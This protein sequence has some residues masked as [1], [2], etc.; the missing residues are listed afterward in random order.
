MVQAAVA[1]EALR[2]EIRTVERKEKDLEVVVRIANSADR[3]LHYIADVRAV[4][5]DPASNTL[6]LA[7][8]DEGR[9]VIPMMAGALP[10]FQFV[11]PGSQAELRLKIP[12]RLI[13][14]SRSVPPGQLAFEK[15]DLS[16]VRNL[17]IEVAWS[18]VPY[19]KDTRV[20]RAQRGETRLP[21]ARWEQQGA[22]DIRYAGCRP[23][24]RK[25]GT[26]ANGPVEGQ[27][28]IWNGR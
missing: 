17:V 7:M 28:I 20:A 16:A 9:Q 10:K 4:R 25:T 11:D 13:K 22:R 21:A 1:P 14:L 8:S 6:T 19:Y 5:Y 15:H 12:D 24:G 18:E 23:A 3:A 27:A 2:A 26:R